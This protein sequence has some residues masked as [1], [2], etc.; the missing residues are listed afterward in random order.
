[1]TATLVDI[2]VFGVVIVLASTIPLSL[3][4]ACGTRGT[5]WGGIVVLLPLIEVS[6]LLALSVSLLRY[7]IEPYVYIQL[8]AFLVGVLATAAFAIRLTS[9]VTGGGRSWN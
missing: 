4:A 8:G 7:D 3:L 6:F 2:I 5:R 9:L 1:M